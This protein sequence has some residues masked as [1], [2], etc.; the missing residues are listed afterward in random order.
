MNKKTI[1]ICGSMKVI[2]RMIAIE[3]ELKSLG[4]SVLLPNIGEVNDYSKMSEVEQTSHKNQMI[5][6]HVEKI[7]KS[8]AVL[9]V[10]ERLKDID[11]YIGA[12][13][14]LEMGMAFALGKKIYLL[15]SIP[16]QANK[17]EIMGLAPIVLNGEISSIL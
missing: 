16:E 2:D 8:D 6:D 13:S 5:I 10:N 1:T 14:F 7:K 12:N 9:I 11:G 17:V 3:A 4:F 15:N